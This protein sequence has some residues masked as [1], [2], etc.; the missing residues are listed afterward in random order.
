MVLHL[1]RYAV[2]L[3]AAVLLGMTSVTALHAQNTGKD[4]QIVTDPKPG[5]NQ[6]QAA[7]QPEPKPAPQPDTAQKPEPAAQPPAA[8]EPPAAQPAAQ[9]P[10]TPEPPAAQPAAQTPAP[11]PATQDPQ[12][13]AHAVYKPANPIEAAAQAVLVKH[14]ARCHQDG[15]L[16]QRQTPAKGFGNVLDLKLLAVNRTL[17]QPGN[18]DNSLLIKQILGE[19]MPYDLFNEGADVPEPSPE[20]I[21]ALRKWIDYLGSQKQYAC[22][23]RKFIDNNAIVQAI[24]A[25]L[26]KIDHALLPGTRY[27][28]LTNLYNACASDK[29]MEVYRQAVVKLLNSLSQNSDV[30]KLQT[31]D[32]YGTIIR[33]N[34][35]DLRW[36]AGSWDLLL[37]VYPYASR[38]DN[39]LVKFLETATHTPL[40]YIRGDWFAYTASRPPLYYDLLHLPHTFQELQKKLGLDVNYNIEQFL[41]KRAGFQA[42]G[43]SANN[44]LIERHT[45][46]TGVFWTSYDFAGNRGRQSL[47]DFPLGPSG[48]YGAK[49][50]FKADGGE[51]I[52]SLPNG[53]QAYYLNAASGKRLDKGPVEIVRVKDNPRDPSVINGLSCFGCHDQ[54]I[55][56][57]KDDIRPAVLKNRA[58]PKD[59]RDTVKLLYPAHNEMDGLIKKDRLKFQTAM[60]EAGLDPALKLN[61][62]EPINALSRR[63]ES[64]VDLVLA[65]SEFG[66][67]KT[68]F[69]EAMAAAGSKAY[70]DKRRLEQGLLPRDHFE[71]VYASLIPELT[72]DELIDLKVHKAKA[73]V[74]LKKFVAVKAKKHVPVVYKPAKVHVAPY[75]VAKKFDLVLFSDK[76]VY[77]VNEHPVFTV[78]SHVDCHLELHNVDKTGHGTVIYP[79]KYQQRNFL[80][81]G[82][83]FQFPG[84]KSPFD[85]RLRDPGVETVIAVCNATGKTVHGIKHNY[86]KA[87]FTPVPDYNK[88]LT[89]QIVVQA[90]KAKKFA[91]QKK[92]FKKKI[93]ARH[94]IKILVKHR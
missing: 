4:R 13:L 10:A 59:V 41:A 66:L 52:F 77:Y 81:A 84:P 91:H 36:T 70:A 87:A 63:Y 50:G 7:P 69:L 1:R 37:S 74:Y 92:V 23:D 67:K 20:D 34:L 3:A 24:S 79:N 82:K 22:A 54:G 72:D 56:N 89:R 44:R 60:R 18:P 48:K 16:L 75:K 61:G 80:K 28:T 29:E 9:P 31:I 86:R 53:F 58:H 94:A 42:S 78:K 35:A 68:P 5:V 15:P 64:N 83:T 26:N 49:Y 47:F 65:A 33:F 71:N 51:T 57:A 62:I 6:P 27:L 38:P 85:F 2:P 90:K 25:D 8:P 12:K 30:L 88:R 55:K 14:C 21:A 40:P 32:K 76:S 39:N 17:V 43:V 93:I 19:D 73:Q 46:S 45:I 11:Q